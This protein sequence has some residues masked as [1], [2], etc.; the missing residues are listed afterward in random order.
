VVVKLRT[1]R[2]KIVLLY[3]IFISIKFHKDM[4]LEY[5]IPILRLPSWGTEEGLLKFA[6]GPY[7]LPLS[8]LET[9]QQAINMRKT[10]RKLSNTEARFLLSDAYLLCVQAVHHPIKNPVSGLINFLW[11]SCYFWKWHFFKTQSLQNSH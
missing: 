11:E 1:N 3:I 4:Q 6:N 10:Q 2:S 8:S 9:I 7:S 5:I